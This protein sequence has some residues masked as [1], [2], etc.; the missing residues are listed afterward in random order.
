M[1]KCAVRKCTIRKRTTSKHTVNKKSIQ[2]HA[3][4]FMKAL[5]L[6]VLMSAL[7][8]S[9]CGNQKGNAKTQSLYEQG[10]EVVSLMSEMTRSEEYIDLFIGNNELKSVIQSISAGDYTEPIAVYAISVT[11]DNLAALS[12]LF[13]VSNVSEK[14]EAYLTDRVFTTLMTQSNSRS[15]AENLAAASVCAAQ[16]TFVNEDA[17]K[18]VIYLYT[19]E[20]AVPVAVT[21]VVGEDSSVSAN[22]TFIMY[23]EFTCGSVDEIR[24]FFYFEVEVTEVFPE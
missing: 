22:G 6:T 1:R 10:L 9:A 5:L 19:Y 13:G 16:K 15:G 7:L 24:S 2:N 4:Y 20:D 3:N 21:F 17:D 11:D 12:E 8:L 23:D 14:L 18:N